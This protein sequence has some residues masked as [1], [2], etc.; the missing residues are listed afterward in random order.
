MQTYVDGCCKTCKFACMCVWLVG[1]SGNAGICLEQHDGGAVLGFTGCWLHLWLD[2]HCC[3]GRNKW[4]ASFFYVVSL[5]YNKTHF[6]CEN[7][8]V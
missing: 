2:S 1:L 6:L 5:R 3:P 8:L 7:I 4:A